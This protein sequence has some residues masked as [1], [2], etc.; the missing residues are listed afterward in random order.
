MK[1]L[2]LKNIYSCEARVTIIPTNAL[3]WSEEEVQKLDPV[4]LVRM[5]AKIEKNGHTYNG[6]YPKVKKIDSLYHVQSNL[7]L[8]FVFYALGRP[9]ICVEII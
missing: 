1:F 3:T 9:N 5:G 2:V 7:I 4:L 8:C 6:E